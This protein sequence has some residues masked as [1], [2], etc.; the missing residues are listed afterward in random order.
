MRL[1]GVVLSIVL[2]TWVSPALA[3]GNKD[4]RKQ[5]EPSQ[6]D[7]AGDEGKQKGKRTPPRVP[8]IKRKKRPEHDPLIAR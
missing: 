2:V 3:D 5:S 1:L 8:E 7:K 6:G 4:G